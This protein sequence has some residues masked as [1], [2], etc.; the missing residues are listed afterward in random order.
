MSKNID[1]LTDCHWFID[2]AI[3]VPNVVAW[4]KGVAHPE[5]LIALITYS[6]Y[7]GVDT[8]LE[9]GGPFFV[10][11]NDKKLDTIA[12]LSFWDS[13]TASN[14]V[15]EIQVVADGYREHAQWEFLP[16]GVKS[17]QE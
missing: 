6:L 17:S 3:P 4:I 16:R 5:K 1:Y 7:E 9:T 12:I 15:P 2:S 13:T 10:R 8:E 11:K 14:W